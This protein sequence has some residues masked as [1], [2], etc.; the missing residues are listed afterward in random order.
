M[1]NEQINALADE[2]DE[3]DKSKKAWQNQ[4]REEIEVARQ[5]IAASLN[6]NIYLNLYKPSYGSYVDFVERIAVELREREK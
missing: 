6:S 1:T 4:L 5:M 2:Y 3:Q